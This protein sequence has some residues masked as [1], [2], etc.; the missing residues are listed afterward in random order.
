MTPPPALTLADA[1]AEALRANPRIAAS[2]ALARAAGDR[3]PSAGL[4]PD[5]VLQLGAMN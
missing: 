3:V 4:P 5:P 1:Y 2:R